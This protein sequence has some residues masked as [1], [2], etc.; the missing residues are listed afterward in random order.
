MG[1]LIDDIENQGWR[2]TLVHMGKDEEELADLPKYGLANHVSVVSDPDS[3]LYRS[4]GLSKGSYSQ[5]FHPRIFLAG[6]KAW[7]AGHRVGKINGDGWQMPGMFLL[8]KGKLLKSH[9][10][11]HAADHAEIEHWLQE[12][13]NLLSEMTD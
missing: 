8:V 7:K 9:L 13:T 12:H 5:H 1:G 3:E 4:F 6:L 2:L 11:E 10:A